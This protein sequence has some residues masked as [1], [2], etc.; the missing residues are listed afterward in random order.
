MVV[1]LYMDIGFQGSSPTYEPLKHLQ[2]T[3]EITSSKVLHQLMSKL[4]WA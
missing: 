3:G 2:L 4:M 1:I